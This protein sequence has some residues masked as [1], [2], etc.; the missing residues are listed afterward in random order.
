[1]VRKLVTQFVEVVRGG[2]A[3]KTFDEEDAYLAAHAA[4]DSRTGPPLDEKVF[5]GLAVEA[6]GFLRRA[7][8]DKREYGKTEHR[9][10]GTG[11]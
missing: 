11:T 6:M 4:A 8:G 7:G 9:K 1:M 3:Y 10:R 2:G 5:R